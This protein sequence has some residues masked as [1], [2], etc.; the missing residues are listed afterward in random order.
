MNFFRR[1]PKAIT[2]PN[3]WLEVPH[4]HN[5]LDAN[6]GRE[7]VCGDCGLRQ[8]VSDEP[9]PEGYEKIKGEVE[10]EEPKK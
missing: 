8:W 7:L 9:E 5:W 2:E 6:E 4:I 1:K 3:P 10:W